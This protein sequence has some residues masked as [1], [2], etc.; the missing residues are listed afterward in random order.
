MASVEEFEGNSLREGITTLIP[1]RAESERDSGGSVVQS[2]VQDP[3]AMGNEQQPTLERETTVGDEEHQSTADVT[4]A[5]EP[6]RNVTRRSR[7]TRRTFITDTQVPSDS[8]LRGIVQELVLAMQASTQATLNELAASIKMLSQNQQVLMETLKKREC[9]VWKIHSHT[10]DTEESLSN[11]IAPPQEE[12]EEKQESG[13]GVPSQD[14]PKKNAPKEGLQQTYSTTIHPPTFNGDSPREWFHLMEGF[15][16][17]VG[18]DKS[19]WVSHA[20]Q[21]LRGPALTYWCSFKEDNL[22][23]PETWEDFKA[24]ILQRFTYMS[25]GEVLEELRRIRWEGS[26]DKLSDKFSQ[27]LGKGGTPHPFRVANVFLSRLP[28]EVARKLGKCNFDKW[29]DC[30][31]AARKVMTPD[32]SIIEAWLTEAPQEV[33]DQYYRNLGSSSQQKPKERKTSSDRKVTKGSEKRKSTS[34]KPPIFCY[35][36]KGKG[37]RSSDCPN[38][39]A[40]KF[41]ENSVCNNCKG[42]GH[43]AQ[44]C[45]SSRLPA[46]LSHNPAAP[47]AAQ[48]TRQPQQG[49]G[50]T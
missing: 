34:V 15:F 18:F 4:P 26:L 42:V 6:Q 21:C 3:A 5:V 36:C 35:T 50:R 23:L 12:I 11:G 48:G 40:T 39:D 43:Y 20:V 37:H 14:L 22:P 33:K 28:L 31:E 16:Y 17:N 46:A 45:P 10:T 24:F 38:S 1:V 47:A 7:S 13:T 32:K 49:N 27:V 44:N 2:A 25:E 8:D 41:K 19:M 29:T 30:R 9:E